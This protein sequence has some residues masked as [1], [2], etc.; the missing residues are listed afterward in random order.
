MMTATHYETLQLSEAGGIATLALNRPEK[1]NAM[2]PRLMEE[3]LRA[4]D[5]IE[6]GP[7]GV[8]VLTGSGHAFCSG[9]DIDHLKTLVARSPKDHMLDSRQI[10]RLMRRIYDFPKPTIAAVNGAAIAGGAGLVSVCDMAWAV[11]EAK[12]G[13]TEVRIGFIPAVVSAFLVAQL[14]DRMAREILLTGRIFKADEALKLGLINGIVDAAE[15]MPHVAKTAQAILANSPGS[16]RGTKKLL[17]YFSA[18]RLDHALEQAVE[19]NAGIRSQP[20]FLEGVSSFLENRAPDW[21]SR[22]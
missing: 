5:E 22:K 17:S 4:L 8:M 12:F 14:G 11:P 10:A 3:L 19:A 15:L 2:N 7:C 16:V 20:D 18:A 21:P 6:A 1:R 13:Y 9:M